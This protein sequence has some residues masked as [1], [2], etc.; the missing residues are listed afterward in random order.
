MYKYFELMVW[1]TVVSHCAAGF[2]SLLRTGGGIFTVMTTG[3]G[4]SYLFLAKARQGG[5]IS[6]HKILNFTPAPPLLNYDQ[7]LK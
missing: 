7:S 4:G 1:T 2:R 3:G 5:K 6:F